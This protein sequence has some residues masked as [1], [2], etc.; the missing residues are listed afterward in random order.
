MPDTAQRVVVEKGARVPLP[1]RLLSAGLLFAILAVALHS[2]PRP[3]QPIPTGV[4]R[5]LGRGYL[6]TNAAL[7]EAPSPPVAGEA[8]P[9]ERN[10]YRRELLLYTWWGVFREIVL[11]SSEALF[12]LCL[13]GSVAAATIQRRRDRKA[14]ER[15]GARLDPK[16]LHTEALSEG[17]PASFET[18]A[19]APAAEPTPPAPEPVATASPLTDS[20]FAPAQRETETSDTRK[21]T[22]APPIPPESEAKE[23][24]PPVR[25]PFAS[26]AAAPDPLM[27]DATVDRPVVKPGGTPDAA[28]NENPGWWPK[29]GSSE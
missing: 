21:V 6:R 17:A 9:E 26:Q 5:S 3:Y 8:A 29:P 10:A 27:H 18:G 13:F 19:R 22:A 25:S 12:A 23:E 1:R 7:A 14:L 16:V 24:P 15:A 28:P 11:R 4:V 2:M 20:P